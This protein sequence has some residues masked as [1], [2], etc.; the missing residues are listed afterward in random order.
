LFVY[1]A[2]LGNLL[3]DIVATDP[4]GKQSTSYSLDC[5]T[6]GGSVRHFGSIGTTGNPFLA[7]VS[8]T[9]MNGNASIVPGG[10]VSAV[11][12]GPFSAAPLGI[13]VLGHDRLSPAL[14]LGAI[15]FPGSTLHVN[16]VATDTI[17][18]MPPL[19]RWTATYP[20]P[21]D[22]TLTGMHL[23]SQAL[24]V[25]AQAPGG[26]VTT[27]AQQITIGDAQMHSNHVR[28][29]SPTSTGGTQDKT[30]GGGPVVRLGGPLFY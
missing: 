23:Y 1:D 22:P 21:N 2:S 9:G 26:F 18:P 19:G 14:D 28:S 20:L 27:K 10:D 5:Q 11:V 7:S 12:G 6:P 30:T 25:D 24:L 3:V 17:F 29:P 8:V 15:G 13:F 4:T 16:P